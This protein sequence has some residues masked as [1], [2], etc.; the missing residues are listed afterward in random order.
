MAKDKLN[1][2]DF[3]LNLWDLLNQ[4][5][6]YCTQEQFTKEYGDLFVELNQ[7]ENYIRIMDDHSEWRLS[8]QKVW[9][10]HE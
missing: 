8:L 2:H 6:M 1:E 3:I 10:D 4:N 7:D 5:D 9:C